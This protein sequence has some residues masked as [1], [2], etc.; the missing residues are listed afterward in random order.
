MSYLISVTD[1]KKPPTR[2]DIL[3]DKKIT[4][5]LEGK[6]ESLGLI[7]QQLILD[8]EEERKKRDTE[9]YHRAHTMKFTCEMPLELQ[10][11][12]WNVGFGEKTSMEFGMIK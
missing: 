6:E 10:R 8:I 5:M 1:L 2:K 12:A 9:I 3:I 7:I 11:F 4:E